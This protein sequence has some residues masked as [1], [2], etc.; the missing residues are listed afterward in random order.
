MN[1]RYWKITIHAVCIV[2][3]SIIFS[4]IT[5]DLSNLPNLGSVQNM[6]ITDFYNYV[7]N[8]RDVAKCDSNIIVI[9]AGTASRAQIGYALQ[10]ISSNQPKAIG[11][12]FIFQNRGDDFVDSILVSAILETDNLVIATD[13][14]SNNHSFFESLLDSAQLGYV[15]FGKP[16][17]VVRK[18]EP[19]IKNGNEYLYSFASQLLRISKANTPFMDD[20]NYINYPSVSFD[21]VSIYNIENRLED[22][23]DK[24]VLIGS[25]LENDDVHVTPVDQEMHGVQIHAHILSTMLSKEKVTRI[26][27]WI[28]WTMAII[29]IFLL[30]LARVYFM[31]SS[32]SAGDIIVRILQL[33]VV[34]LFVYM[35]YLLFIHW[36]IYCDIS[37]ATFSC[38]SLLVADIWQATLY[39]YAKSRNRLIKTFDH[40]RTIFVD[41]YK[42]IN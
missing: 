35:G 25:L 34:W 31:F 18:Y 1:L 39:I 38:I 5:Y 6:D 22:I 15:N 8:S 24:Y 26:N 19:C 12:D 20:P 21:T 23:Q 3:L 29:V 41:L 9:D 10:T 17:D 4:K 42:K 36:K 14:K 13:A 32:N 27:P 30:I 11:L 33:F 16:Y 7:A 37:M 28:Q 40:A 2:V